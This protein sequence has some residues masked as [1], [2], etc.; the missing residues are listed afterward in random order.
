MKPNKHIVIYADDDADDRDLIKDAFS[1]YDET[2]ELIIFENGLKVINYLNTLP[3]S[4]NTPC[5]I[6]LDINMPVMTGK[7]VLRQMRNALRLKDIPVILFTTSSLQ[8]DIEYASMY[9]AAM[10]TKP[11]SYIKIKEIARQFADACADDIKRNIRSL[12]S[13]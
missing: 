9:D 13:A 4:S 2:I 3:R 7:E 5:L 1:V 12:V 11:T 8:S 6:I 10:V